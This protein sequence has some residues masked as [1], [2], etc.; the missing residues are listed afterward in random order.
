MMVNPGGF[1]ERRS[2]NN[3]MNGHL[4]SMDMPQMMYG[5]MIP[6]MLPP[7]MIDAPRG[8]PE[9]GQHSGNHVEVF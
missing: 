4:V 6:R 5:P 3:P 1:I 8:Y 9:Y 7:E 2:P